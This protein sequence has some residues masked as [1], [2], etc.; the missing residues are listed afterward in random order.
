VT[1][2]A[3]ARGDSII[4]R[5]ADDGPGIPEAI[6][7]RVFDPFFTTKPVGQGAGLGLDMARRI[8]HLHRGDIEFSPT[9][10]VKTPA[11]EG[12]PQVSPDG[13]WLAYVS[14]D[15]GQMEVYLRPVAGVDR[16]WPM[17][18]GGGF[19]PLWSSNSRTIYYRN[20]QRLMAV[21]LTVAPKCG[22]ARRARSLSSGTSSGRTSRSRTT[23]SAATTGSS[24]S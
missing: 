16:R 3:T 12:A 24:C 7:A 2:T 21:D 11:Y 10:I 23:P 22:S 15:A 8:V 19:H 17:S 1:I 5:V 9:P 14:N 6:R 18:S 20:G 13:Q 4:V